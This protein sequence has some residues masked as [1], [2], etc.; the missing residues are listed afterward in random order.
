MDGESCIM[1][2]AYAKI[3]YK[4]NEI[5]KIEIAVIALCI[6]QFSAFLLLNARIFMYIILL[7]VCNTLTVHTPLYFFQ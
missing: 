6:R 2:R 5:K 7:R 1:G 4:Y 3:L